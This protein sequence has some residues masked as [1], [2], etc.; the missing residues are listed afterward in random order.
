MTTRLPEFKQGWTP[1][2]TVASSRFVLSIRGEPQVR[3]KT[4]DWLCRAWNKQALVTTYLT[5]VAPFLENLTM[6]ENIW[7]PL[8]W[9]RQ[10]TLKQ[11]MRKAESKLSL[12]GWSQA[13]LARL[14]Q[15]RPGDLP[16]S[17]VGKAQLL[18]ASLSDPDWVLIDASW[19]LTPHL[20]L[21]KS[22]DI[23]NNLLA[24][25]RWLLFWPPE[26][27]PLPGGVVWD[28]IELI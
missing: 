9:R 14:M 24:K 27:M 11:V 16:H 2:Q 20:P 13:E 8:T 21:E 25:S 3:D 18:R 26:T 4:V 1:E 12:F 19:F 17:V 23:L 7:L 6:L 22:I 15:C 28:K 10:T 5:G